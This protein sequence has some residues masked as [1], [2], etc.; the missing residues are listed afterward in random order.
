MC[1]AQCRQ[2]SKMPCK[3]LG[4][5]LHVGRHR[6]LSMLHCCCLDSARLR[7][8][9]SELLLCPPPGP[10]GSTMAGILLLGLTCLNSSEN[11]SPA[12]QPGAWWQS[13]MPVCVWCC[14][15]QEAALLAVVP[16]ACRSKG[17]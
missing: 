4:A 7:S 17:A 2:C 16:G 14:L 15:W 5:E 12:Q 8:L 11:W 1:T 6:C 3:Q 10:S 9:S 13:Y